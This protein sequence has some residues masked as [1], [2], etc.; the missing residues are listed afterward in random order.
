MLPNG[1]ASLPAA[2]SRRREQS[3]NEQTRIADHLH[4]LNEG[5]H[6]GNLASLDPKPTKPACEVKS[7]L[8][9]DHGLDRRDD[10]QR[11]AVGLGSSVVRDLDL[12]AVP[13]LGQRGDQLVIVP[14][15][16]EGRGHR[17]KL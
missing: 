9:H 3:G 15:R 8:P 1:C 14:V 7:M 4:R 11:S 16:A 17:R 12:Q 10:D 2:A 13:C 6:F 5:N